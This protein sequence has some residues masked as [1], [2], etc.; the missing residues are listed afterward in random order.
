MT[1]ENEIY[2]TIKASMINVIENSTLNTVDQAAD[3][4][5]GLL[6]YAKV[7]N[8]STPKPE[9]KNLEVTKE[10][11]IELPENTGILHR[12]LVGG[13]I[14]NSTKESIYISEKIIRDNEFEEGD[15]IHYK[16]TTSSSPSDKSYWFTLDK[17]GAEKVDSQ[18][19]EFKKAL[20]EADEK[21]RLYVKS[22]INGKKLII[23]GEESPYVLTISERESYNVHEGDYIDLAWYY[24]SPYSTMR[25]IWKHRE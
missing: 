16:E 12:K 2:N 20:V 14:E 9:A 11:N 3:K 1:Y 5:K 8:K 18:R 25:V 19:G 4:I 22:S 23:E 13:V 10:L 15:R 7:L 6:D 17:A 21:N 24:S